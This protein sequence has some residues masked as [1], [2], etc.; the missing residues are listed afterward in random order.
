MNSTAKLARD[1]FH[2]PAGELFFSHARRSSPLLFFFSFFLLPYAYTAM[3]L[4]AF[5]SVVASSDAFSSLLLLVGHVKLAIA[6]HGSRSI[7]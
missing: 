1:P 2:L 5:C 7:I 3:L 4:L 6:W